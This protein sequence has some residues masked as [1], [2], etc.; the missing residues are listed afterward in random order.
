M[1]EGVHGNLFRRRWLD[2]WVGFYMGAP[3]LF[4]VT[5]YRVSHTLHHRLNRTEGDP[6]EITNVSENPRILALTFYAWLCVGMI[7]YLV[8]VPLSALRNG[9]PDGRRAVVIEHALLGG[10]YACVFWLAVRFGF[11]D[12]IVHC[13]LLPAIVAGLFG[14]VRGWAEHTMTVRGH[15]LTQTRTVTSKAIVSFFMC[16]LNYHLEHHL[17]PGMPWYNLRKLHALLE[18]DYRRAASFVYRSYL[19]F[20]WDALRTGV[21]GLAPS[22]RGT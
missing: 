14:N 21:H 7:P 12:A 11:V 16:N 13:W 4:S 2:R 22:A 17:H 20:L 10:L 5:A 19:A 15:P 6:N 9:R 18:D 1:H 8:H 3:S